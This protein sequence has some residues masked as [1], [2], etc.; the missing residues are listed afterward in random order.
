MSAERCKD[1]EADEEDDCRPEQRQRPTLRPKE[2]RLSPARLARNPP[3]GAAKASMIAA[4]M[5]GVSM[6]RARLAWPSMGANRATTS[7][8]PNAIA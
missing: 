8:R 2:D 1:G 5:A 7:A 3:S 4:S 6:V